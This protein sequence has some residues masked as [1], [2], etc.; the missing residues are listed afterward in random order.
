MSNFLEAQINS[1]IY[2][3]QPTIKLNGDVVILAVEGLQQGSD[4]VDIVTNQGKLILTHRQDCCEH[5]FLEDYEGDAA[6]LVGKILVSIDETSNFEDREDEI[7]KWTFYTIRTT[8]G[9]LW[10]RWNGTSNGYYSVDVNIEWY[11]NKKPYDLG[12]PGD[13]WQVA[14]DTHWQPNKKPSRPEE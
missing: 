11:P 4:R 6:D 14:V 8:G 1:L 13:C 7:E 9:D 10:L 12:D 2:R 5:V 3:C